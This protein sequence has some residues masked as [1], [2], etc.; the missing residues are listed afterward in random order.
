VTDHYALDDKHA[1]HLARRAISNLNLKKKNTIAVT[2]EEPLY[3]ADDLYGIVGGNLKKTF[4]VREVRTNY[5]IL[6]KCFSMPLM[7]LGHCQDCGWLRV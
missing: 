1:I 6:Y 3:P 5:F 7:L 2:P 4:D